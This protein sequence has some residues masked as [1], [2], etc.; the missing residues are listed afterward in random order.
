M[1]KE[2]WEMKS[3]MEWRERYNDFSTSGERWE[4]ALRMREAGATYQQIGDDLKVGKERARMIVLRGQRAR[5][6]RESNGGL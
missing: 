2:D 5:A 1:G 4:Y 3:I 6:E